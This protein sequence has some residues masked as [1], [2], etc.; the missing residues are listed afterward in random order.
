MFQY[1][2]EDEGREQNSNPLTVST[3]A[4]IKRSAKKTT[5]IIKS[6]WLHH[7][8]DVLITD[9][10]TKMIVDDRKITEKL[11]QVFEELKT[12]DKESRWADRKDTENVIK[13]RKAFRDKLNVPFDICLQKAEDKI[14]TSGILSWQEDV[15]HLRNQLLPD[16]IGTVMG[17]DTRQAKLDR[18]KEDRDRRLEAAK[19]KS[20]HA[21][22]RCVALGSGKS[23]P[24]LP[25]ARCPAA[26]VGSPV[27]PGVK[28]HAARV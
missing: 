25:V 23:A 2:L 13:K 14:K 3:I 5:P 16:Q 24:L 20:E 18:R 15:E 26:L 9:Q 1:L 10:G 4:S 19:E 17:L 6:V 28:L 8:S 11:V 21:Y 12:V 27:K 7:F 22:G